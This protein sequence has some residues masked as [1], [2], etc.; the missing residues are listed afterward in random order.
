MRQ[1]SL[2]WVELPKILRPGGKLPAV[3]FTLCE[4]PYK[5]LLFGIQEKARSVPLSQWGQVQLRDYER[6]VDKA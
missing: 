2:D 5:Q 1:Y 6:N 3:I 4:I